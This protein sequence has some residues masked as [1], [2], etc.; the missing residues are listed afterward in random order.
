MGA[1]KNSLV[2]DQSSKWFRFYGLTNFKGNNT[3]HFCP[4][5]SPCSFSKVF[6]DP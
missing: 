6:G 2:S 1:M 3:S 5:G 4:R